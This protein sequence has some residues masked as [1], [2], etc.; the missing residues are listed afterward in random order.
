MSLRLLLK[1]AFLPIRRSWLLQGLVALSFAQ[2]LVALWFTG[3]IKSEIELTQKYAKQARFMTIQLKDDLTSVEPIRLAVGDSEAVVEELKT[4]EVMKRM[5]AEESEIIQMVRSIGNEGLQLMPRLLVVRGVF[6]NEAIEKIKLM[7]EVYKVEVSPVHH[8]RLLS[9]YQHLSMEMK[10]AIFIIL[11]LLL[12]QLLVFHRIQSRDLREVHQNL[13]A[14][15]VGGLSSKVPAFASLM[16]LAMG[17]VLVSFFEWNGFKKWIWKE[18]AFLGELSFY[19]ELTLPYFWCAMVILAL[20][21]VG[22]LL[23]FSGSTHE[24]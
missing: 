7:T 1:L 18:N 14:W 4:D 5:E 3:A 13:L 20:I 22:L 9:F 17:A 16:F 2:L 19:H 24:E 12:V 23:S 6:S 15:G 11:F 21:A 8:A 10:I